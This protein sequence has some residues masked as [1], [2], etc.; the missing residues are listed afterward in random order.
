MATYRHLETGKR[1]L[2]IHIPRT[3]GRFVEH[4]LESQGWVWDDNLGLSSKYK[5]IEGIEVAHF[6]KEFYEKHLNVKDIP[7]ICIVRNPID[8]FISASIYLK[9]VYGDDIQE[10]MEDENYFYSMLSNFPC[11]E[12]VNWY[13][14]QVDFITDKSHIWKFENGFGG[15]FSKWMSDLVGVEITMD[16]NVKYIKD[17]D[18]HNKLDKTPALID[19][20][21][22]LYQQDIGQLYPELATSF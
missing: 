19:N 11:S 9:R 14:P 4:N 2:F 15:E 10:L 13:R 18:E 5:S 16:Q 3:A 17:P 20:I 8:R 1:F 21:R 22:Q 12:S 7:H 6:H